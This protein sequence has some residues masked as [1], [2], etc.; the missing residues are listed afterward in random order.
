MK[1]QKINKTLIY[2][3]TI[4]GID[5]NVYYT[6]ICSHH[7]RVLAFQNE[8]V[9]AIN[10]TIDRD[11]DHDF[12]DSYFKARLSTY[13]AIFEELSQK[14]RHLKN[15]EE[16][17]II[18]NVCDKYEA[19]KR[20]IIEETEKAKK[21]EY[22]N[23]LP[24]KNEIETVVKNEKGHSFSCLFYCKLCKTK[25]SSGYSYLIRGHEV[26]VCS[27]CRTDIRRTKNYVK[28]IPT[29]MGHSKRG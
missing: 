20:Q 8:E 4:E 13:Q 7:C 5:F 27:Y 15:W 3:T 1:K 17:Y 18:Y 29:N 16:G 10:I 14:G 25:H 28:I 11:I 6:S 24:D 2:T 22:D 23:R 19:W 21:A 26:N 12:Y 9:R